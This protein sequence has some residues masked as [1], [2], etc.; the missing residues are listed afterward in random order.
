M[1]CKDCIIENWD[2]AKA[3]LGEIHSKSR[4]DFSL[5]EKIPKKGILCGICANNCKIPEGKFG[6]C[7]LVKNE[8]NRLIRFAGIPQKGLLEYYFD[9]HPTNC[10]A[11]WQCAASGKGYP[12]FSYSKDCE[13]GYYNMAVFYGACSMNCLFCQNWSFKELTKNLSPLISAEELANAIHEKVSCVCFFGGDPSP[14]I[15]HAIATAKIAREKTKRIL[16]FC[17]ETNG[18]ENQKL[19][20]KFAEISLE[21]GGTIKFDLKFFSEELSIAI[22]GVS[23]KQAYK[24]FEMLAE[25]HKERKEPSFLHVST[26]L[27]PFYVDENEVF[28]IA[29]FVANIDEKIPYSLLAFYPCFVMKDLP[30]TSWKQAIACYN[31]AKRAG[32]KN[33]RIGNVHLLR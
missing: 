1:V 7:G 19:L 26:L 33:V 18:L 9:A 3:I 13:Y 30:T 24:N 29:K 10:V 20:K 27:I 8:N 15:V 12:K 14:Q 22:S 2:K 25:F 11:S 23:N 4:K 6:F 16:R 28:Q 21:S 5:P 31:A 17:L 32:L